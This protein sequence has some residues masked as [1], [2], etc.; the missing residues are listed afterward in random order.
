MNA[1]CTVLTPAGRGA[2]GVVEV[3][4]D[5]RE[6]LVD[7]L[8]C[9][10]NGRSLGEQPVDSV[11]F[12]RWGTQAGEELVVVRRGEVVEVHCHGGRAASAAIVA[13]LVACGAREL[14]TEE[15]LA[16]LEPNPRRRAARLALERATTERVALVLVDQWQ[17]ALGRECELVL[18]HLRRGEHEA[19]GRQ[20]ER[21]SDTWQVGCWLTRPARIVLTGPPNVGKSSLV[22]RL[23][24]YERAIVFDQPGTTRDVVTAAT[25]I[26]GWPVVLSDTAGIRAAAGELEQ[27]GIALALD[28]VATA[29][30]VVEVAEAEAILRASGSDRVVDGPLRVANKIDC[31]GDVQRSELESQ[32]YLVTCATTGDGLASLLDALARRLAPLELLPGQA[33]LFRQQEVDAIAEVRDA[34]G[35]QDLERAQR[36]LEALVSESEGECDFDRKS[37][38]RV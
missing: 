3:V 30:V 18:E 2:V 15:R 23:V 25:A 6:R 14:A 36:Q 7:G 34:L 31:V 11:R 28:A 33:V 4:G 16:Q 24:G 1:T 29:D 22:N 19:A 8:F 26:D 12:G 27:A 20:L 38:A 10:A 9:A 17:G 13:S 32:G 37:A 21:L 35:Q 5:D